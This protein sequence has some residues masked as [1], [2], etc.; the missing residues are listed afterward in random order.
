MFNDDITLS[1]SPGNANSNNCLTLFKVP[2]GQYIIVSS[3]DLL[4]YF[5]NIKNGISK[6]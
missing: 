1:Y 3:V 4:K 5:S 6:K 2:F